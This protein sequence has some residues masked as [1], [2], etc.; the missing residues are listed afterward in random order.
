[1]SSMSVSR[2]HRRLAAA[3]DHIRT[4]DI[5][6][7][8]QI[9]YLGGT[10]EANPFMGWRSVRLSFEHPQFFLTQI[11]AVLRAAADDGAVRRRTCG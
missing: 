6:G 4:L 5:G 7:D 2:N 9:A 3:E 10:R 8:K 1:M 11:R